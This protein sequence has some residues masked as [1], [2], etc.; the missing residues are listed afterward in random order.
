[1]AEQ[2]GVELVTYGVTNPVPAVTPPGHILV[3]GSKFCFSEV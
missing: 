2:L 1:M 3:P